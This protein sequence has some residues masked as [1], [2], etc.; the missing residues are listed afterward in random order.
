MCHSKVSTDMV[1]SF[2]QRVKEFQY[3]EFCICI[4]LFGIKIPRT[5]KAV[6]RKGE[7]YAKICSVLAEHI[8]LFCIL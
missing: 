7:H 4:F 6:Y 2:V 5:K 1:K 8:V 3:R